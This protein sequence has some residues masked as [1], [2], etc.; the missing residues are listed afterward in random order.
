MD[1]H[2]V[3]GIAIVDKV[4]SGDGPET[5]RG[6]FTS[7]AWA[8]KGLLNIALSSPDHAIWLRM[9]FVLR[10]S[11]ILNFR[12]ESEFP[13]FFSEL[14]IWIFSKFQNFRSMRAF[15]TL[16]TPIAAAMTLQT[17]GSSLCGTLKIL[18]KRR[19]RH[20]KS[21]GNRKTKKARKTPKRVGGS[22]EQLKQFQLV[23]AAPQQ[24]ELCVKS[25]VFHTVF[26]VKFW[27]P[28]TPK[29]WKT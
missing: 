24:S 15:I 21:K 5:V 11:E 8:K 27:F 22:A 23:S 9:Q 13:I 3:H 14:L 12:A 16:W 2:Q 28:R 6:R 25:S 29:P 19:A 7:A 18:E 10:S 4:C 17:K 1:L 20:K 26:D